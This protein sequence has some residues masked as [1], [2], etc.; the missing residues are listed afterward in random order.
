MTTTQLEDALRAH[1]L[2]LPAA[3][4]QGLTDLD[5]ETDLVEQGVFDSI[6]LLE[7]VVH[8]EK[9]CGIKVPGEDVDPD[10]FGSLAAIGDYLQACHGIG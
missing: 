9:L 10:N 2:A 4:A 5:R 8:L 7:F 3:Q 6:S 1:I